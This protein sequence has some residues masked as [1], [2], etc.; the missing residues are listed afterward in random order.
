MC[1][2]LRRCGPGN[3]QLTTYASFAES[4][5]ADN[6]LNSDRVRGGRHE[7]FAGR[8]SSCPGIVDEMT[9]G[10]AFQALHNFMSWCT[11]WSRDSSLHTWSW[12]FGPPMVVLPSS[13]VVISQAALVPARFGSSRQHLCAVLC[14]AVLHT[15]LFDSVR[16]DLH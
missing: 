15:D 8:F 11:F 1:V 10:A 13:A 6:L 12:C 9:A 7:L 4:V 5:P 2:W 3:S 14:C 16:I